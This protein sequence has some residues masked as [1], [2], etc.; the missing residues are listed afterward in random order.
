[1]SDPSGGQAVHSLL[2]VQ[3]ADHICLESIAQH[4]AKA[5]YRAH[6]SYMK[7]IPQMYVVHHDLC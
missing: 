7:D 3:F 1:M 6:H 2:G 5:I 4:T